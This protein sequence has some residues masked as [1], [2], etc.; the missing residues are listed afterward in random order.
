M[1]D[2][3]AEDYDSRDGENAET[4]DSTASHHG[5]ASSSSETTHSEKLALQ[6]DVE[7]LQIEVRGAKTAAVNGI[8]SSHAG[9]YEGCRMYSMF[10]KYK[11]KG[12][13]EKILGSAKI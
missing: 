10:G 12:C 11:K 3:T 6:E 9:T 13:I 2:L 5:S 4:K 7:P 1:I 8:Y